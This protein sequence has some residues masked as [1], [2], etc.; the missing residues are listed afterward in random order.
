MFLFFILNLVLIFRKEKNYSNFQDLKRKNLKDAFD[1]F[2][3]SKNNK[4][5]Q[6]K[7]LCL[8]NT[9]F[10]KNFALLF[11]NKFLRLIISIE[12][13]CLGLLKIEKSFDSADNNDKSSDN[14]VMFNNNNSTDILYW[15]FSNIYLDEEIKTYCLRNTK[16][17]NLSI[18]NINKLNINDEISFLNQKIQSTVQ[19]EFKEEYQS[20]ECNLNEQIEQKNDSLL[21]KNTASG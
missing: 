1:E 3:S 5:K 8:S 21:N 16:Y 6:G 7:L 13:N 10:V 15:S 11:V 18:K 17:Q 19:D 14:E 12:V 4:D 9:F 20:L 2:L